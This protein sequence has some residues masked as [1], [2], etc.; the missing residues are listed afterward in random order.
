MNKKD[1]PYHP[2]QFHSKCNQTNSM[3]LHFQKSRDRRRVHE[4]SPVA[5]EMSG[6]KITTLSQ[7]GTRNVQM[8]QH[9]RNI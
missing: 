8:Q 7:L 2:G 6:Q 5:Q 3:M 1:L 4:K 9:E